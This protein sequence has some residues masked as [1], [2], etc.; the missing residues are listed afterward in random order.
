MRQKQEPTIKSK[1]KLKPYN[2]NK[3]PENPYWKI[4]KF[5]RTLDFEDEQISRD[6]YGVHT[7]YELHLTAGH[8]IVKVYHNN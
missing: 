3:E 2:I 4:D 6:D 5:L 1:D 7:R 8:Y